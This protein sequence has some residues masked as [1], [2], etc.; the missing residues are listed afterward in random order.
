MP[1]PVREQLRYQVV[2]GHKVRIMRH[3]VTK[4]LALQVMS[5]MSSCIPIGIAR[6]AAG[7]DEWLRQVVVP[8]Q[9][10]GREYRLCDSDCGEVC[11]TCEQEQ[12]EENWR[13]D[14]PE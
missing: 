3:L 12:L 9:S 7:R 11:P 1:K 8:C 13:S 5:P 10:C 2:Q 4:E 6:L 14:N